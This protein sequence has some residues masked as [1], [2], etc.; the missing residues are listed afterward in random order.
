MNLQ[1]IYNTLLTGA[2]IQ[3]RFE[4]KLEAESFRV[5]LFA[6]KRRD[7]K[8]FSDLGMDHERLS[9]RF[10]W[11]SKTCVAT[12]LLVKPK[13]KTTFTIVSIKD[14]SSSASPENSNEKV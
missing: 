4:T 6:K 14:P 2:E 13:E 11:D 12:A 8:L 1:Q 5:Q 7:D 3:L 10:S 9:L